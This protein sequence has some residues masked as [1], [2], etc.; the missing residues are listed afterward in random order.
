MSLG[1]PQLPGAAVFRCL[2]GHDFYC[3]V[4]SNEDITEGNTAATAD[5]AEINQN[6][7]RKKKRKKMRK[8]D[9]PQI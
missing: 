2:S 4:L 7:T 8:E 9:H 5:T 3:A 1:T 6:K